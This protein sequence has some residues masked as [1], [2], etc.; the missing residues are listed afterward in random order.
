MC[1]VPAWLAQVVTAGRASAPAGDSRR[2]FACW[3]AGKTELLQLPTGGIPHSAPLHAAVL[4]SAGPCWALL[5]PAPPAAPAR[6]LSQTP[7]AKGSPRGCEGL[8]SLPG[9]RRDS[10]GNRGLFMGRGK[11]EGGPCSRREWGK[12]AGITGRSRRGPH[13][14]VAR[15]SPPISGFFPRIG[16]NNSA[17]ALIKEQGGGGWIY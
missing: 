16:L 7:R 12:G 9:L 10:C 2:G 4:G 8:M 1:S 15:R 3:Q 6:P 13:L 17:L 14:R 5:G 11:H